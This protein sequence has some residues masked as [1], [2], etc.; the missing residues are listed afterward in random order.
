MRAAQIKVWQKHFIKDGQ[1]S[2]DSGP[3]SGRPATSRTPENGEC[4]W[5]AIN[6]EW[7]L[8]VRGLEADVG[9]QNL[10]C[11]RFSSESQHEMC[12]AKIRSVASAPS[13]RNIMLQLLMM[14]GGLCGVPGCLL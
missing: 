7:L 11:L 3:L 2:V 8:T 5:A 4:T 10:L 6:K 13:I 14:L 12:H 9:F 1:E